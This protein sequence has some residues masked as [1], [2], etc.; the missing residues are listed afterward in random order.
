MGDMVWAA[1]ISVAVVRRGM[2]E[3]VCWHVLVVAQPG[4]G[5]D[6]VLLAGME[7]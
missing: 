5:G 7:E 3:P 6:T 2:G 4:S 1:M